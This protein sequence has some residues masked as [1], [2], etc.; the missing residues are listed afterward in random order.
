FP[1]GRHDV[2][3]PGANYPG[4][5]DRGHSFAPPAFSADDSETTFLANAI[6]R[7]LSVRRDE[8]WFVHGVFL[9]PH[10]PVIAPEPYNAMYDPAEVPMPQRK[11]TP[12][13]EAEQ[14]PFLKAKIAALAASKGVDEHNPN[15]AVHMPELELRQ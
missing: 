12:D 11:K 4:A 14:H 6:L 15:N 9:R 5:G 3:R 2:Y 13:E 1:R 7:Y 8:N 10:P